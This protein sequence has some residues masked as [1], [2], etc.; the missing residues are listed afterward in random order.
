MDKLIVDTLELKP[1]Y[2]EANRLWEKFYKRFFRVVAWLL[3]RNR[4]LVHYPLV[5][6][7]ELGNMQY[8]Y[9]YFG[10]K[11]TLIR[12]NRFNVILVARM[13][14]KGVD[15]NYKRFYKTEILTNAETIEK[16]LD[17]ELREVHL[18]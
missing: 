2:Q 7:I 5:I 10:F 12:I 6:D 17:I 15:L 9:M 14:D 1:E 13:N 18:N 8:Q 11:K 4:P 3:W 16:Q